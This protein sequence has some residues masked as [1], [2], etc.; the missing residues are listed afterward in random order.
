[1]SVLNEN[2]LIG[3]SAGGDYEIE[4]SLRFNGTDERLTRTFPSAGNRKVWT[5][6]GWVKRSNMG[7]NQYI[8]NAGP[9]NDGN[10]FE[11]IRFVND[12]TLRGILTISNS[13]IANF[14]TN[15]KFRDPSAWYHIVWHRNGQS[16]K[17][18]VN[19]TEQTYSSTTFSSNPDGYISSNTEH[20]I[21]ARL[22][23]QNDYG[24]YLAEVNFI[25]SITVPDETPVK[26]ISAPISDLLIHIDKVYL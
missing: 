11:G 23:E 15:A 20:Q 22:D 19:G 14:S 18:Y 5:W 12:D 1:M 25:S 7:A 13:T 26:Y 17:I 16:Y 3:A 6:S 4:Q 24:G 8:F 9:F 21:G 10:N 2:Q